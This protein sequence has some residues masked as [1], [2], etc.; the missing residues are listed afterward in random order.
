MSIILV[1]TPYYFDDWGSKRTSDSTLVSTRN[2]TT[3]PAGRNHGCARSRCPYPHHLQPSG[4]PLPG[5]DR[6][7][8]DQVDADVRADGASHGRRPSK[9]RLSWAVRSN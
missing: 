8:A 1:D 6:V 3:V 5:A 9:R 7:G 2:L 4:Q